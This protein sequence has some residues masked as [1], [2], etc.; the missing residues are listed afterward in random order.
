MSRLPA[1]AATTTPWS[2]FKTYGHDPLR[3]VTVRMSEATGAHLRQ[4]LGLPPNASTDEVGL[5]LDRLGRGLRD[6]EHGLTTVER[7]GPLPE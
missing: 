2:E 6:R 4:S 5:A 7:G 3:G 1:R